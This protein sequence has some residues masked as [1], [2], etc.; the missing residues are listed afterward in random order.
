MNSFKASLKIAS[1][2]LWSLLLVPP[3]VVLMLFHRGKY[4]YY[5]PF[6]W[7]NGVRM[8]FQIRYSVEGIPLRGHQVFYMSN[9]LSYL[10]VPLLGSILKASFVA[11]SEVE[12]W[13]MFGF[14]SKLQ[15][16]EFIERKRTSITRETGKLA[17]KIANGRSLILFPEGTSTSGYEVEPFKSSLFTL[18]LG[19]GNDDVFVQ[20]V[21][22]SLLKVNGA[23]PATKEERDLYA[24]PLDLDMELPPHLFRFAKTSGAD[25]RVIFHPPVRA[26]DFTD[27]K[28]LAKTCHDSV[29]NGLK[30]A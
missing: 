23:P 30:A 11:K 1:F 3:Q 8:I 4:A 24:W 25:L 12:K 6:L 17:E 20:P 16:T 18:A 21:T 29:S 14:L 10:D 28:V 22:I 9:H 19:A 5:I 15:Q 13:P 26:R 27:R 7:E 2:V